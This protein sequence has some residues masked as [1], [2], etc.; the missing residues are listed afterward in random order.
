MIR[1]MFAVFVSMAVASSDAVAACPSTQ[2]KTPTAKART[3]AENC[4]TRVNLGAVSAIS[5]N[6]V[7]SEPAPAVAAPT[8]TPPAQTDHQGPTLNLSKPEPGVRPVPTV[9]YH[10][11]LE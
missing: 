8:Y 3:Q 6:I 7:N 4:G 1:I 10:W 11:S 2:Q 5:A 9:G